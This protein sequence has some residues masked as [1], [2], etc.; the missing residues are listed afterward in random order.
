MWATADSLQL[1][2]MFRPTD[3]G[4]ITDDHVPLLRAGIHAIDVIGFE[5]YRTWHH[6]LA[7]T[8]DKVSDSTLAGVGRLA[9]ALLR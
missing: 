2:A 9:L 8:P 3:G 6:T 4:A 7:D 5:N 1:G